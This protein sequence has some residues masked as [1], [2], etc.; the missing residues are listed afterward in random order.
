MIK[1]AYD[2]KGENGE[3]DILRIAKKS[4]YKAIKTD[5]NKVWITYDL[6]KL[7]AGAPS[8]KHP[9]SKELIAEM[10][11]KGMPVKDIAKVLGVSRATVYNYLK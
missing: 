1:I 10:K 9:K 2:K 7:K 11:K 3:K 6:I 4:G 5:E 8:K